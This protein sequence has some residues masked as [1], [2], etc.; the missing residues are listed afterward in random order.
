MQLLLSWDKKAFGKYLIG[1]FA[2]P[3]NHLVLR[4]YLPAKDHIA[5]ILAGWDDD[6]RGSSTVAHFSRALQA[7]DAAD[8]LPSGCSPRPDELHSM[9]T[10]LRKRAGG[11][12]FRLSELQWLLDQQSSQEMVE[13]MASLLCSA[14]AVD[15]VDEITRLMQAGA[16]VEGFDK[17]GT[18]PLMS[19]SAHGSMRA[20]HFLLQSGAP[21]N[22]HCAI[23]G[24]SVLMKASAYGHLTA[25]QSLIEAKAE[26]NTRALNG[27][28]AML[29][30]RY[31]GHDDLA[32]WLGQHGADR[33][34]DWLTP[35]PDHMCTAL[36]PH[37][38][39]L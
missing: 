2:M 6:C 12:S 18:S 21:V 39:T 33:S 37:T 16:S 38:G 15:D 1:W 14:A 32:D 19:A 36:L 10:E 8:M 17:S 29:F 25:V 34:I 5:R 24:W 22:A 13:E 9:S 3:Y 4:D 28:T 30:A 23:D 7:L 27:G 35:L 26:P 11:D 31:Y 20:L